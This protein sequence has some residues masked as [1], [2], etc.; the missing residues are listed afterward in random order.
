[1]HGTLANGLVTFEH[2]CLDFD[3]GGPADDGLLVIGVPPDRVVMAAI[4]ER[5]GGAEDRPAASGEFVLR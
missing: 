3:G 5:P 2:C 1:M 4:Y